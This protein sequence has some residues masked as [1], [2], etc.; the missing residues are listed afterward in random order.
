MEP[1][2]KIGGNLK[3]QRERLGLTQEEAAHRAG[4]HP[5]EFARAERGERDMRVS[6][7][8]KLA[9]GLDASASDLMQGVV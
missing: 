4:V 7:V 5:V 1:K 3:A 9:R 6:T 2:T 8:A